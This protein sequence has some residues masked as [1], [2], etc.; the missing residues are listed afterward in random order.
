MPGLVALIIF[1]T[2][3]NALGGVYMALMDPY[4]LTLVSVEVWGLL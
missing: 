2:I 1:A 3:N 4:G